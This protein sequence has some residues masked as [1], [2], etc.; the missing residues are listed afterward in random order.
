MFYAFDKFRSYLMLSKVIMYIDHAAIRYLL[1]RTNTKP[2]LIRW[3]FLL[4]DFNLEIQDK[5]GLENVV[6]DQ[7]ACLMYA[8]EDSNRHRRIN[9]AF[10]DEHIYWVE[11]M[12]TH[13]DE[14]PWFVNFANYM[15]GRIIS[16]QFSYQ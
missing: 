16:S 12:S 6:A 14:C 9:D 4:Q 7:L 11:K 13:D 2:R 3:I 1:S 15:V 10:L 8:D 5:K